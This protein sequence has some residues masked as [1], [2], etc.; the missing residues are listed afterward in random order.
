MNKK[1]RIGNGAGFWG[2]HLKA[3]LY[4]ARE[5]DLDYL[6]L[7]YLAEVTMGILAYQKN[8]DHLF[9]LFVL[10]ACTSLLKIF[11]LCVEA[12]SIIDKF[13]HL[14]DCNIVYVHL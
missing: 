2:D 7:E 1:I 13:I 14:M 5:G 12:I 11:N 9:V 3:P 8:K 4:L 10:F 6:T